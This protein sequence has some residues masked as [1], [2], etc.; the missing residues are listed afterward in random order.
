M[1]PK[2]LVTKDEVYKGI[3]LIEVDLNNLEFAAPKTKSEREKPKMID[4]GAE[5]PA[6]NLN[7]INTTVVLFRLEGKNITRLIAKVNYEG[8]RSRL[9]DEG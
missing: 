9:S 2:G 4:W 5:W 7:S 8:C 3:G 1:T 6:I